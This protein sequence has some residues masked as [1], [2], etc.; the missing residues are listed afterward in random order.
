[1]ENIPYN[2]VYYI[3]VSVFDVN[4]NSWSPPAVSS[5]VNMTF[6]LQLYLNNSNDLTTANIYWKY[7]QNDYKL[8]KL[9]I[10]ILKLNETNQASNE[11]IIADE[12]AN[13]CKTLN[14][15]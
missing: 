6:D 7:N 8:S 2:S 3:E 4:A 11:Y 5:L 9:N 14:I 15:F 1:M 10:T 12:I 13:T